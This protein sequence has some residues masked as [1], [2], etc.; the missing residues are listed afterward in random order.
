LG[1]EA[2]EGQGVGAAAGVAEGVGVVVGDPVDFA[3]GA[4]DEGFIG[5][6]EFVLAQGALVDF[7]AGLGGQGEEGSAG[8]AG[9]D[10]GAD[11]VG[12]EGLVVDH[13]E[14]AGGAFAEQAVVEEGG[15]IVA[16]GEGVVFGQDVGQEG[17][18]F[19]PAAF[20][21][22]IGDRAEFDARRFSG[23]WNGRQGAGVKQ[24]R[25]AGF[26]GK[27][28]VAGGDA[29]GEL[30]IDHAFAQSALGDQFADFG[31]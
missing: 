25:R 22:F 29:A 5:V 12:D 31:G 24:E 3:G 18:G 14:V 21:A 2:G 10:V 26:G 17:D 30:E 27:G 6:E 16:V 8:D 20:P 23:R 7:Q 11:G 4:G 13:K 15:F 1:E 19:D 9:E 28:V